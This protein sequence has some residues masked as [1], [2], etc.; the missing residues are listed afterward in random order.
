MITMRNPAGLLAAILLL[1]LTACSGGPRIDASS[2]QALST[3][4][5]ALRDHLPEDKRQ[6]FE[7]DLMVIVGNALDPREVS[8]YAAEQSRAVP[9]E[10]AILAKLRPELHGLDRK[11]L[12]KKAEQSKIQLADKAGKW[13]SELDAYRRRLEAADQLYRQRQSLRATEARLEPVEAVMGDLLGIHLVKVHLGF[14]NEL[15]SPINAFTAR[16]D[17]GSE[18]GTQAWATQSIKHTFD[19]PLPPGGTAQLT[20]GPMQVGIPDSVTGEIRLAASVDVTSIEQNIAPSAPANV[21]WDQA[22]S[23][24]M[25]VLEAALA[26]LEE[27]GLP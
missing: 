8:V 18:Q 1:A 4:T 2:P 5:K 14:T 17:L 16:V 21:A 13:K 12:H 7:R 6:A 15:D 24:Q 27:M 22:D 19:T 25:A 23:Y 26:A 3:S 11:G 20:V 10:P 9:T